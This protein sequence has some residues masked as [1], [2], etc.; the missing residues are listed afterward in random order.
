[1]GGWAGLVTACSCAGCGRMVTQPRPQLL[2][3]HATVALTVRPP[4]CASPR[5]R[6][7]P[8]KS[9]VGSKG[10]TPGS[11]PPP[12]ARG[13][14][15]ASAAAHNG[16]G[17]ASAGAARLSPRTAEP[18]APPPAALSAWKRQQLS[19][20]G[21][22]FHSRQRRL[23]ELLSACNRAQAGSA[24]APGAGAP[25]A[26]PAGKAGRG[27]AAPPAAA[28][29]PLG[30]R[31]AAVAAAGA[32]AAAGGESSGRAS[33]AGVVRVLDRLREQDAI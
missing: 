7:P 14:E 10:R 18:A 30:P 4:R 31:A 19:A 12:S 2:A 33:R 32:W 11:C 8:S 24:V 28:K 23:L 3:T 25:E 16:G 21:A 1:M 22:G 26:A 6:R 9:P 15:N 20:L 29:P 13:K 27:V 5:H 17:G